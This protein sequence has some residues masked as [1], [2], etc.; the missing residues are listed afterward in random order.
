VA[1]LIKVDLALG[2]ELI[3]EVLGFCCKGVCAVVLRSRARLIV[4]A[5]FNA[6]IIESALVLP[7]VVLLNRALVSVKIEVLGSR[8][9]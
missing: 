1:G 6:F 9:C 4:V 5:Y 8:R 3:L 2:N 7:I